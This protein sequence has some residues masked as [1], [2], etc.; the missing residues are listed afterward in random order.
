MNHIANIYSQNQAVRYLQF[1]INQHHSTDS[2]VHNTL[3]SIYASDPTPD[4]SQL[5]SYLEIQSAAHE[6]N[7]DPDFA[8]RLCITHKRVQSA[9]HIYT[10]MSQFSSAVDLALKHNSTDLAATVADR[11]ENDPILRKKLWLKVAKSVIS[12]TSSIKSA[13][14]FLKRCDLL[15]IE[16]LIPFFPDF[17]II[18]DFRE[19]ICTALESYSRQIDSLRKEMDD[20]ATTAQNIKSDIRALDSRYAIV[21]PGERCWKCGF[22]L[23]MRQ[24]FVFPCQHAFHADCLGKAVSA[25]VGMGKGRRIRELQEIVAGGGLASGG[26][27]KERL[28]KELDGLVGAA[29]VLCSEM[30]VRMVDEPFVR[31]GEGA[32]EWDI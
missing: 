18:D 8:L 22:P 25:I 5:L 24:F 6:Q 31:Q 23:L 14:S 4:E 20:S 32:G 21:E 29:C 3:I 13:I 28:V 12:Q 9:V 15:R 27:K 10:T 26:V 30:A 1:C 7:Y 17:V 11:P 16:D 2:A 19:E